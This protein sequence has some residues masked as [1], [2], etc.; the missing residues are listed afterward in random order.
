MLLV[1]LGISVQS[2]TITAI[3]TITNNAGTT[4]GQTVSV[5]GSP[6]IFSNS[7]PQNANYILTGTNIGSVT[8]NIF[9]SYLLARQSGVTLFNLT[10][11]N[12][13][14]W[15]SF[16]AQ[17]LTVAISLGFGTVAYSTNSLTNATVVR[18]PKSVEG[19]AVGQFVGSELVNYVNAATNNL[20][21][22]TTAMLNFLDNSS[23]FQVMRGSKTFPDGVTIGVLTV[24]NAGGGTTS[25]IYKLSVSNLT[26]VNHGSLVGVITNGSVAYNL[27]EISPVSTNG[28]SKNLTAVSSNSN[29]A[30]ILIGGTGDILRIVQSD[31]STRVGVIDTNGSFTTLGW[32]TAVGLTNSGTSQFNGDV[33]VDS[34]HTLTASGAFSLPSIAGSRQ[35]IL[36]LDTNGNANSSAFA[37]VPSFPM[38]RTNNSGLA[39]GN[40]ANVQIGYAQNVYVSG[41]TLAF[42][43][44]GIASGE[45]GQTVMIWNRTGK[46]MTIANQSGTDP[47][48]ANR[49][50]TGIGADVIITNNPGSV[51]LHYDAT[52]ARWMMF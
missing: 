1:L 19:T 27:S 35:G 17:A 24:T 42:T 51:Q 36:L 20:A 40:N 5:N 34:G 31:G 32:I 14:T 38:L 15:Q 4:N 25:T 3:L 33:N 22:G 10:T 41:P 12:S 26:F 46:N 13:V 6:R 2:Q 11:T 39:N 47:T 50:E 37:S 8:T 21:A 30:L 7:V 45:E 29:P 44:N 43:I 23:S 9:N 48:P 52:A 18:V 28:I 16:P 49:I